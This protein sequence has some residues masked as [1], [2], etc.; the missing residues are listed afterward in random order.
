MKPLFH[1]GRPFETRLV[2]PTTAIQGT[3]SARAGQSPF[4]ACFPDRNIFVVIF[5]LPAETNQTKTTE[6]IKDS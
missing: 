2:P 5:E 4:S 3:P 1:A 6:Q